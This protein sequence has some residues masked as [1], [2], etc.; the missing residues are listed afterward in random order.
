MQRHQHE[1][2]EVP[3]PGRLVGDDAGL[4]RPYRIVWG[5]LPTLSELG[6]SPLCLRGR[7]QSL[8]G[9][10]MAD[11]DRRLPSRRLT[12]DDAALIKKRLK[13]GEFQHRI[14]ADFDVNPGRIAEIKHGKLFSD[15][16]A[17]P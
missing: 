16:E 1:R 2:P 6:N 11:Q 13:L 9:T 10:L 8:K 14:A 12:P 3:A 15:V 5:L 7:R 17:A 4:P